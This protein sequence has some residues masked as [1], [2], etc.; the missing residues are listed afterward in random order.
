MD[1]K[2]HI[3][4]EVIVRYGKRG[5]IYDAM[6]GRRGRIVAVSNDLRGYVCEVAVDDRRV[7]LSPRNL[8]AA[9]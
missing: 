3:G 8:E 9:P 6:D 5:G 1:G 2:P 4:D 7:F